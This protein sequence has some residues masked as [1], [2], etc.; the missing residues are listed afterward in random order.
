MRNKDVC[1]RP[2]VLRILGQPGR[3]ETLEIM[4]NQEAVF[5]ALDVVCGMEVDEKTTKWKSEYKGKTYYFCGPM[6]KVEFD[7]NPAK[8]IDSDSSQNK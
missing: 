6:C 4:G 8:S 1:Y 7:E 3:K 5:V 2:H